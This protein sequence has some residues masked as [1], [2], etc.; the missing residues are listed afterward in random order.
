MWEKR[1]PAKLE[2][3]CKLLPLVKGAVN[4][5][6]ENIETLRTLIARLGGYA[7][8]SEGM[9][10]ICAELGLKEAYVEWD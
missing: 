3:V 8:D 4:S 6:G 9:K 5:W 2:R 1:D 7:V 10:A